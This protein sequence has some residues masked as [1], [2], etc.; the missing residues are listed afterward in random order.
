[1]QHAHSYCDVPCERTHD[2]WRKQSNGDERD[3]DR[4][5]V[6]IVEVTVAVQLVV[7]LKVEESSV[8]GLLGL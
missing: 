1:M 3:H 2:G 7:K 4:E 6:A 8:H 5:F